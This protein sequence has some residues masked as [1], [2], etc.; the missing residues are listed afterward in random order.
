METTRPTGATAGDITALWTDFTS[1]VWQEAFKNFSMGMPD[2]PL[3]AGSWPGLKKHPE[4]KTVKLIR[5]AAQ[6]F[7]KAVHLF[8]PSRE[9]VSYLENLYSVSEF[10]ARMMQ[11]SIENIIEFQTEWVRNL[12]R[13]GEQTHAY[14]FD[15]IDP[16]IF[17]SFRKLYYQE[18]QKYVLMPQF[19]LPR[20]FQEKLNRLTDSATVFFS[21][22]AELI[23]LFGTAVD[24][25]WQ[26]MQENLGDM[27]L[28]PDML[29]NPDKGYEKW[30]KI[31]EGHFMILLQSDE[32]V[33]VLDNTIASYAAYKK[34]KDDVLCH[35]LKTFPIPSNQEM[36]AV[37]KELYEIKKRINQ[38][39]RQAKVKVA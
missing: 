11:E 24:K 12:S 23:Y 20:Y 22:L 8:N 4:N 35:L 37:Y 32:Y 30:I 16:K 39:S 1:D 26:V 38:I 13:I 2:F 5:T 9:P 21:Y 6:N 14:R 29:E 7:T 10:S 28:E 34:A 18:F 33:T 19:G 15:D 25:S 36:D 27:M 17:E 3:P 31:L